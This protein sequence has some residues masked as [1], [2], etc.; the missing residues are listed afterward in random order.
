MAILE[1]AKEPPV[2]VV[3]TATK[4]D[5]LKMLEQF[6]KQPNKL[7]LVPEPSRTDWKKISEEL[8]DAC[9]GLLDYVGRETSTGEDAIPAMDK[10]R[11][12]VNI[13]Q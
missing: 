5:E 2:P 12:A 9:S 8:H 11:E 10:Y 13:S 7:F 3:F 1:A 4:E 6:H